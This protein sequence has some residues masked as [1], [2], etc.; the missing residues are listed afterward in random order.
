MNTNKIFNEFNRFKNK[1]NLEFEIKFLPKNID[2]KELYSKFEQIKDKKE[3]SQTINFIKEESQLSKIKELYFIDGEQQK[4]KKRFY[5][6]KR[7][8]KPVF[9]N[10]NDYDLKLTLAEENK[11]EEV[12]DYNI[13]RFKNRI[14]YVISEWRIDFTFVTTSYSKDVQTIKEIKTKMFNIDYNDITNLT[15]WDSDIKKEIEFEFMGTY[16]NYPKIKQLLVDI[17]VQNGSDIISIL[18][19][20][21]K[22]RGSTLK[23]I[24]PNA[25]EI[26]K[27]QYFEEII[28]FMDQFYVTDKIDG[29]RTVVYINENN[30]QYFD[31]K[32]NY[33]E[34]DGLELKDTI[35]ECEKVEGV[36]YMYD[37]IKYNG[38]SI[39]EEIFE[40]RLEYL[41]KLHDLFESKNI[42]NIK[43]KIFIKLSKENYSKELS[44]IID[45]KK[46]YITDGLIFTSSDKKYL[47]TKYFK[48]KPIE[49]TTIDFLCKKCPSELLGINPYI[50]K[51]DKTLYILFCGISAR[52][53][54]KLGLTKIKYYNKLFS[55]INNKYF[56]IQFCPST[57]PNAYLFWIEKDSLDNKIIELRMNCNEWEF[58]KIREDRG[59]DYSKNSSNSN[60]NCNTNHG[61]NVHY[62]GN[63]FRVAE[64]IHRNYY[65]PLSKDLLISSEKELEKDFY[66][67]SN[68]SQEHLSIRKFNNYVKSQVI[69]RFKKNMTDNSWVIDIASGKGQDLYKFINIGARNILCIDNNENN[70]CE[71]I[72][73]KY[74]FVNSN[75]FDECQ[76]SI[77]IKNI[78]INEPYI[79]NLVKLKKNLIVN[80]SDT[81]LIVCNFALH[82]FVKSVT[83]INNFIS[84]VDNLMPS[85]SRLIITCLNGKKIYELLKDS[86][87]WGD[88]SRYYITSDKI[89]NKFGIGK[90]ISILL[91]FSNNTLYKEYLVDIDY[92]I[93]K[94]KTKKIILESQ[95]QFGS[96][97]Q[98][99][100]SDYNSKYEL[101]QMDKEYLELLECLVFWKK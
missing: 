56:P 54:K 17:N 33:I 50:V 45:D 41:Y 55:F 64:I 40:K 52:E 15:L 4:D 63:N 28:P 94:F 59:Y 34:I 53:Y 39:S 20:E 84:F 81:K 100:Y 79:D 10:S 92:I 37:I 26:N 51:P 83:S 74:N 86:K 95:I 78:D 24:L 2:L 80:K 43:I 13:I 21:L 29:L 44:K 69:N 49:N 18:N 91:P 58:I 90:E 93:K 19:I 88:K 87:E 76:T 96:Y 47:E 8:L 48:W 30:Q 71:I 97:L 99:F 85:N 82:Y 11:I 62:Y 42:K 68:N 70:L 16:I 27:R 36:F 61:N 60:K 14:S 89:E 46:E 7:L 66:F 35:I 67:I 1:E 65:N 73:R 9:I 23:Q 72:K 101:D 38:I 6:K 57:N 22:S 98:D 12:N 32:T 25:I 5:S 31:T 77:F 3:I 75:S